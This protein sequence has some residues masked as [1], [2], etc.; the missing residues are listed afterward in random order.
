MRK[1]NNKDNWAWTMRIVSNSK[2]PH[3]IMAPIKKSE[4]IDKIDTDESSSPN[5]EDGKSPSKRKAGRNDDE[6]D[7]HF[8]S[9]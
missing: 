1:S 5:K 4:P 6:L 2:N 3:E 8:E 9:L 7:K